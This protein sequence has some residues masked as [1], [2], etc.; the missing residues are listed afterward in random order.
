MKRILFFIALAILTAACCSQN[1]QKDEFPFDVPAEYLEERADIP[2][3]WKAT[4]KEVF[5]TFA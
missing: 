2:V 5:A 1:S 3:F 4:T